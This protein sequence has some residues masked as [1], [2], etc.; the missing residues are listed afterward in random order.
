[1]WQSLRIARPGS[2]LPL[3]GYAAAWL[4][5][6]AAIAVLAVVLLHGSDSQNVSLPPVREMQLSSA[7]REARCKLVHAGRRGASLTPAVDG[8]TAIPAAPGVY[9]QPPATA[10]LI[11]ALRRGVVV[12]QV[13]AAVPDGTV[14]RLADLQ[15]ALPEGTIVTRAEPGMPFAIAVTAYRRLLGCPRYTPRAL[16]AVQLFRGRFVGTGPDR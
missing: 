2:R 14:D 9:D 7:A 12:I 10:A 13:G 3:L 1:M 6:A 15:R 11:G 8:P 16:D 4:V 5:A